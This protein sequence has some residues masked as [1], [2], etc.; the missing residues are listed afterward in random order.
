[1]SKIDTASVLILNDELNPTF[2]MDGLHVNQKGY[3]RIAEVI[4]Q[5]L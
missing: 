2:T 4:K 1:M 3:A 5:F